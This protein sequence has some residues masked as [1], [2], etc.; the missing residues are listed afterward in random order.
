MSKADA[1]QP[2]L[3]HPD[4]HPYPD[5][6]KP[7]APHPYYHLHPLFREGSLKKA[8][9][10]V[11]DWGSLRGKSVALY[12]GDSTKPKCANFFPYLLQLY[13]IL[14]EN[15]SSQKVEVVFV[16]LDPNKETA[17]KY[18][19]RM[20]WLSVDFDDPIVDDFKQHFRVMNPPEVPKYGY[21]PRTGPPTVLVIGSDGRLLRNLDIENEAEKGLN[22]WDFYGQRF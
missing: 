11:H 15:G 22:K 8:T 5:I 7:S 20:P 17:E 16:P 10:D 3:R 21:G 9:G 2:T 13:K 14:N 12:F 6:F 1:Q 4:E 18:R 19:K